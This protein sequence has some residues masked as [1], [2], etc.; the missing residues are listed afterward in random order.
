MVSTILQTKLKFFEEN[1]HGRILNR[2]SKDI[3]VLDSI[4]YTYL[5]MTD[6]QIF[7]LS[8]LVCCQMLI[9]DHYYSCICAMVG[10]SCMYF[11]VDIN[12]TKKN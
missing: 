1:T 2:F 8:L 3:Q 12:E 5:D 9:H 10:H 6:V 4:I 7:A 11:T